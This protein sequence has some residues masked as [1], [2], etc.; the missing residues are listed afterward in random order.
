[1]FHHQGER[2]KREQMARDPAD[3]QFEEIAV[4]EGSDQQASGLRRACEVENGLADRAAFRTDRDDIAVQ[5]K[6]RK[7]LPAVNWQLPSR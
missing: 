3:K 2:R 6:L 7:Q 5:A 4:P 1:M